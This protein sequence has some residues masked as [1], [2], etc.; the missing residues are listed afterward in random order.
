[1]KGSNRS[2]VSDSSMQL[3][4]TSSRKN[5]IQMFSFRKSAQIT[6]SLSNENHESMKLINSCRKAPTLHKVMVV[7]EK[8]P[9]LLKVRNLEN[10]SALHV[11]AEHGAPVDVILFLY[12][13]MP[14]MCSEEDAQGRLPLHYAAQAQKWRVADLGLF[15]T[16]DF[17]EKEYESMIKVLSIANPLGAIHDDKHGISPIEYALMNDAPFSIVRYLQLVSTEGCSQVSQEASE[18]I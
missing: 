10:Q 14:E 7:A 3:I 13:K 18:R 17:L 4:S 9:D 12:S 6:D 5:L 15:D 8:Y 11:A 2:I 1:M 16:D